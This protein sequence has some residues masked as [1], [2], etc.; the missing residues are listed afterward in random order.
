MPEWRIRADIPLFRTACHSPSERWSGYVILAEAGV[1]LKRDPK[2]GIDGI[3]RRMNGR[4]RG[5]SARCG[6]CARSAA[7]ALAIV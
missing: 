1:E 4:W 7:V 2:N 3:D 6:C 5:P